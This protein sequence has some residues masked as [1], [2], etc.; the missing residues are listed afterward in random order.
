[1]TEEK[2]AEILS[3]LRETLPNVCVNPSLKKKKSKKQ[4]A[5]IRW[6]EAMFN[7]FSLFIQVLDPNNL[8]PAVQA[9][10]IDIIG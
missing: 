10:L 7:L 1:M 5:E 2:K 8:S 4:E 6:N 9:K 3:V